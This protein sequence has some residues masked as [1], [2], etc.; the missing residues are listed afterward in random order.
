MRNRYARPD[1]QWP[2]ELVLMPQDWRTWDVAQYQSINGDAGGLWTPTSPIALGGSGLQLQGSTVG[3][4]ISGTTSTDTGGR[5]VHGDNDFS[6]FASNRT[7]TL[8][9]PLPRLPQRTSGFGYSASPRGVLVQPAALAS[10][11]GNAQ[12]ASFFPSIPRRFLHNGATLTS[13]VLTFVV[14]QPRTALP[15]VL[16]QFIISRSTFGSS[17]TAF[18][19][20]GP[21]LP[22][23]P[24]WTASTAF[25]VGSTTVPV[26]ANGYIYECTTAGTTGSSQPT[27]PI[28][29][30]ATVTDGSVVWT[31]EGAV[32]YAVT[33]T[34]GSAAAYLGT[35]QITYTPTQNNVIDTTQYSYQLSIYDEQGIAA[36]W[37]NVYASLTL[38]YGSIADMRFE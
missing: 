30:G 32:S 25:S 35:Q 14:T 31:C 16:P 26:P 20:A 13:A 12:V 17:T 6:Q 9:W 4:V 36:T 33:P 27:W 24:S 3:A 10:N 28:T 2:P 23:P 22:I 38:N 15:T 29:T 19:T 5:L 8:V 37:G 7:R 21:G 34:P 1:G 11:V 18:L